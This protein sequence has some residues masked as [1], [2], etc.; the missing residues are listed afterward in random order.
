MTDTEKLDLLLSQMIKM[1]DDITDIRKDV[2]DTRKD[3]TDIRGDVT[4]IKLHLENVTDRNIQI[5]AEGHMNLNTRLLEA[6]KASETQE[7]L[8]V[9]TSYLEEEVKQIKKKL[10]MMA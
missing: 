9:R 10:S 5:V 4:D 6:L 8:L 2:A 3:V 1:Q 7:L